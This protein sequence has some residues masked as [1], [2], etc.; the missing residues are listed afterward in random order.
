MTARIAATLLALTTCVGVTARTYPG[1]YAWEEFDK[2]LKSSEKVTPLGPGFAGEAVSLSNGALSFSAT[3]VS[4][5]GNNSLRVEFARSYSVFSRKGYTD[6]GMM[7]DWVVD[8]P[9]ISGA[10]APD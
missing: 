9:S 6:L 5:P 10:F 4:L 3:D 2:R 8:V 7:A 1:K